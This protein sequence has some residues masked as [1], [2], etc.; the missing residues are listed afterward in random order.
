MIT[1]AFVVI[2][3]AI[4]VRGVAVTAGVALVFLVIEVGVVVVSGSR[5]SSRVAPK[6]CRSARSTPARA[7]VSRARASACSGEFWPLWASNQQGH[8]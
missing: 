5:S 4:S 7:K 3:W 2:I 1:I 8:S 6:D